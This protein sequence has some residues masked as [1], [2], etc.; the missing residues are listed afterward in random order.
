[1]SV[2]VSHVKLSSVYWRWPL[3]LAMV[4]ICY[5]FSYPQKM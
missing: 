3:M 4:V 2:V 1:M 5:H